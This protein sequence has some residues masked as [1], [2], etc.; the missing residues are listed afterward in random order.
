MSELDPIQSYKFGSLLL[1]NSIL[2]LFHAMFLQQR[3]KNKTE[4]KQ[5]KY[6]HRFYFVATL[7][8]TIS[9]LQFSDH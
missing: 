3:K 4:N 2:I 7:A 9:T 8:K 6:M 5:I 1:T